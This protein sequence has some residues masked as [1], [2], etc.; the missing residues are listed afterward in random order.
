MFIPVGNADPL[1]PQSHAP[2]ELVARH[3]DISPGH[4]P[5]LRAEPHTTNILAGL[6]GSAQ[7][8]CV[9]FGGN[10]FD[11]QVVARID[12]PRAF[13]L[14]EWCVCGHRHEPARSLFG[15]RDARVFSTEI[16]IN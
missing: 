12:I 7:R 1:A 2:A 14:R 9:S 11:G 15:P 16:G 8:G 4:V 6:A 3:G 13:L 5:P 10:P